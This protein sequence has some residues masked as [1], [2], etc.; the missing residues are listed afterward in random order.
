MGPVW[1]F[2]YLTFMPSRANRWAGIK[3]KSN[4]FNDYYYK[5][6]LYDRD[7]CIMMLNLWK[8]YK[9]Y[10]SGLPD[11]IDTMKE[12]IRL[13][14]QFDAEMWWNTKKYGNKDQ[15]QNGEIGYSDFDESVTNMKL[16]FT[17]KWTFIDNN[18]SS[19][20]RVSLQ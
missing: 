18:I 9:S 10:F 5:Y 17:N 8:D 16:G 4:Q 7:F 6:F 15:N 3:N 19:L 14:E 12:K 20:P 11:Y 2:D 13:S 1:D